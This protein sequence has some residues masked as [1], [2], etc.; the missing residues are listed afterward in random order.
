MS[1]KT[2]NLFLGILVLFYSCSSPETVE[3]ETPN[4]VEDEPVITFNLNVSADEGGSVDNTGGTFERGTSITITATPD[5]GYQFQGWSNGST[6]NPITIVIDQTTAL[7]AQ[8]TQI[9][10]SQRNFDFNNVKSFVIRDEPQSSKEAN[11]NYI[12]IKVI[13]FYDEV[14]EVSIPNATSYN[15]NVRE[16]FQINDRFAI[17]VGTIS[18][19]FND[20]T[21]INTGN[22][23]VDTENGNFYVQ[24]NQYFANID[25]RPDGRLFENPYINSGF[26]LDSQGRMHFK[27]TASSNGINIVPRLDVQIQGQEA[28]GTREDLN[29]ITT[30]SYK[31]FYSVNPNGD[32]LTEC[33]VPNYGREFRYRKNNGETISLDNIGASSYT[34]NNNGYNDFYLINS[35]GDFIYF[36][37]K[38]STVY[39]AF[40]IH[41]NNNNIQLDSLKR[42][43]VSTTNT[44]ENFR[45]FEGFDQSPY[46][47]ERQNN[48]YNRK[49]IINSN[50]QAEGTLLTEIKINN[51]DPNDIAIKSVFS[52]LLNEQN[53]FDA[54]AVQ[55]YS[56]SETR[57][58]FVSDEDI[59][60]FNLED[61]SSR[62]LVQD[63]NIQFT[64]LLGQSDGTFMFW[65]FN[66]S[67]SQKVLGQ[68]NQSGEVS[69]LE[70][71]PNDTTI[72]KAIRV[73]SLSN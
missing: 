24:D 41:N 65:G 59:V 17:I 26:Q 40:R 70:T 22:L 53:F 64:G 20:N 73:G 15:I 10:P 57:L 50:Y 48:T 39:D 33:D 68:I 35:E 36:K 71:I 47:I 21:S 55:G 29:V 62:Y 31:F 5:S 16:A 9:Q 13:D 25:R 46:L 61:L 42:I 27:A 49:I 37:F 60:E 58:A 19:T 56:E 14:R 12:N 52:S 23:L 6:E 67:N 72:Y 45:I 8:F 44:P 63:S 69:I 54:Y 66:L 38:E 11:E 43:N 3:I 1:T 7:T 28:I 18:I 30:D 4:T 32:I 51:N 2:I 34:D